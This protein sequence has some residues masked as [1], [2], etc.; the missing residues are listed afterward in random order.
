MFRANTFSN[1]TPETALLTGAPLQVRIGI[2][3]ADYEVHDLSPTGFSIASAPQLARDTATPVHVSFA[4]TPRLSISLRAVA[5][6][7]QA[8]EQRQWFD[9]VDADRD[10]LA[11]LLLASDTTVVH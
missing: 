1:T 5:R 2:D 9:F 6:G 7:W 11:V 4:L 8:P 3:D 10:I